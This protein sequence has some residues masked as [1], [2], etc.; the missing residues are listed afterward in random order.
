MIKKNNQFGGMDRRTFLKASSAISLGG[1]ATFGV[2]GGISAQSVKKYSGEKI[3]AFCHIMPPKFTEA[4]F[5]RSRPTWYLENTK[6]LPALT[7][8]DLRLKAMDKYEGMLQIFS[9]GMPPIEHVVPPKDAVDLAR[10]ANDE[11]AEL[12]NKYPNRFVGAVAGLPMNDMDGALRET[13]RVIKELKFKG[14]QIASS[15]NGKPLDRPEFLGLYEMM[16]QYDLPIWIHPTK[17]KD[18]PDYPD[19]KISR[20]DLFRNF[21][22]AFE[23]TKAMH[24][25]VFSGVMEKYPNLKFFIHHCGA[26]LPFFVGRVPASPPEVGEVMKLTKPPLE[27]FKKF[28]VDTVLAGN[29]SALMCGYSL[30]GA[31]K[32]LFASDYP[33]PGGPQKGDIA[34]GEV[35]ESV[36]RMNVTDEEKTKIFSKNARRILKLS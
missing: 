16:A 17:D 23:T 18:I 25:L 36:E 12:V 1:A 32:M 11:M 14:V 9:L 31:D 26:M 5:K 6:T 34:L 3:D 10:M 27:Y 22:W 8:L 13:E 19:E 4:L 24:R 7:N 28:Y 15:I 33:Y 30:F 21:A 2:P 35:I 29:T 20:Y